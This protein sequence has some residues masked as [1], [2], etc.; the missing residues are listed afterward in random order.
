MDLLQNLCGDFNNCHDLVAYPKE[1]GDIAQLLRYCSHKNIAVVPFGG[2][3]SVVFGVSPPDDRSAFVASI[4]IDM[5]HFNRVVT[6]DEPSMT[7]L[8]QGGVYGP[9]LERQL[10]MHSVTLR[11]F[12]QSFEFST[13]GGWLATRSGGHFAT[14]PTHIDDLCAGLR[15]VTPAGSIETRRL[16]ASGAGPAECRAYLGSEGALGIITAAWMRVRKRP[17][18]RASATVL[19]RGASCHAA[20]LQVL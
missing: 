6:F 8:V 7:C 17:S 18:L 13:V 15:L 2:G 19:F 11:H 16:P 20:F 1:E 5:I 3:S 14:G 4:A 12:P 9:N 10:K